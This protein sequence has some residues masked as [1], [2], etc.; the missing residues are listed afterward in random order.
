M[1]GIELL[2]LYVCALFNILFLS[3][4]VCVEFVYMNA[5]SLGDQKKVLD[6]LELSHMGARKQSTRAVCA[7]Q[8]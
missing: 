6:P 1:L 7:P 8:G 4:H 5:G 2:T 3:M